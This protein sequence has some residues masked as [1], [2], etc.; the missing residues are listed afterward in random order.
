M[1]R[2]RGGGWWDRPREGYKNEI[3]TKIPLWKG[4]KQKL[5][6]GTYSYSLMDTGVEGNRNL[7]LTKSAEEEKRLGFP[8]GGK[9][10]FIEK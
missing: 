7:L 3:I 4:I 1:S 8:L 6:E 5:Q 9:T 10:N 2:E